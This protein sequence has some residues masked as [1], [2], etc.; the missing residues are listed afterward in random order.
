[1]PV[2][3]DHENATHCGL[4]RRFRHALALEGTVMANDKRLRDGAIP[5]RYAAFFLTNQCF[6]LI[7]AANRPTCLRSRVYR[8]LA[9]SG[10]EIFGPTSGTTCRCETVRV[11]AFGTRQNASGIASAESPEVNPVAGH[12]SA[13]MS[14][15]RSLRNDQGVNDRRAA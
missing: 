6:T 3:I 2:I 7:S 8:R 4:P 1:M 15:S 9:Q 12:I 5:A 11:P 14:A 13:R 10:R